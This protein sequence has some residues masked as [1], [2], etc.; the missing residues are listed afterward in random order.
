[1]LKKA[2]LLSERREGTRRLYSARPE[3][4]EGLLRFFD[5][6]RI[7]P[8]NTARRLVEA[9]RRLGVGHGAGSGATRCKQRE[10]E[11]SLAQL[12]PAPTKVAAERWGWEKLTGGQ[13]AEVRAVPPGPGV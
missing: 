3:G 5:D 6:I 7:S 4:L 2:G 12:V 10:V 8:I 1:V 9:D 13:L 11:L